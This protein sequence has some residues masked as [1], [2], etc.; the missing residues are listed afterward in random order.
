MKSIRYF[1]QFWQ[2]LVYWQSLWQV[3]FDREDSLEYSMDIVQQRLD[4][5][6]QDVSQFDLKRF[7]DQMNSTKLSERKYLQKIQSNEDDRWERSVYLVLVL[8]LTWKN[9]FLFQFLKSMSIDFC[10]KLIR[11][12]FQVTVNS[13]F[14]YLKPLM[15]VSIE[16]YS[17]FE[18]VVHLDLNRR[19]TEQSK[20]NNKR[21]DLKH[22]FIRTW[23]RSNGIIL[24]ISSSRFTAPNI[25][26]A[27]AKRR[28]RL[29]RS[30][31]YNRNRMPWLWIFSK[32]NEI[33]V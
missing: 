9:Y 31:V 17:M 13:S 1:F 2:L 12:R 32:R 25:T 8:M 16:Y 26:D 11:F 33:F 30:F 19:L 23:G 22:R 24:H 6:E 21:F 29:K 10:H 15:E 28:S 5:V 14:L 27:S 7:L 20:T 4:D 3:W 18:T